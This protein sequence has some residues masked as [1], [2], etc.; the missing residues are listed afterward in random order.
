MENRDFL[1]NRKSLSLWCLIRTILWIFMA[2][3]PA[4]S[5]MISLQT[6]FKAI[7]WKDLWI[8][9]GSY[10]LINNSIFFYQITRTLSVVRISRIPLQ[11]M[12]SI[13]SDPY[14]N[15]GKVGIVMRLCTSQH[16]ITAKTFFQFTFLFFFV[17]FN[18]D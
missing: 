14:S 5:F 2:S 17:L 11:F 18:R 7:G 9:L 13:N 10:I 12:N 4:L 15:F 3:I 16:T 6:K 8:L 1:E